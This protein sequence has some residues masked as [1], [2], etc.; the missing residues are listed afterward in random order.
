M[1][2]P[3]SDIQWLFRYRLE[4][5]VEDA[6]VAHRKSGKRDETSKRLQHA[7][8]MRDLHTYSLAEQRAFIIGQGRQKYK[9]DLGT[10][11][12]GLLLCMNVLPYILVACS[13]SLALGVTCLNVHL[14]LPAGAASV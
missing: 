13:P 7:V 14:H 12:V 2:L 5:V 10:V 8:A 11:N 3:N 4:G 6:R 1:E 9:A